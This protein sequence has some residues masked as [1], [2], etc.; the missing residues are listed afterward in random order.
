MRYLRHP[1]VVLLLVLAGAVAG[2]Q[3]IERSGLSPDV[4][5]GLARGREQAVEWIMEGRSEGEVAAEVA[6]A[7]GYLERLRLGLGSPFRLMDYALRDPRLSDSTRVAVAWS[8]LARTLDGEA[9]EIDPVVLDGVDAAGA[10]ARP[11]LGQYHLRLIEGAVEEARDPRSGELAVRLAYSLAAA[12]ASVSERAPML[13]AQVAALLRDRKLARLD[14]LRLLRAAQAARMD[15]VWLVPAWRAGRLFEVEKPPMTPLALEAE[16]EALELAP[17]L[18]EALRSLS[19]RLAGAETPPPAAPASVAPL[20]GWGAAQKLV[21]LADTLNMPPETPVVVA[22]GVYRRELLER[23]RLAEAERAA[24]QRFLER[25]TS[26]ERLAAEH[27]LLLQRRP[28]AATRASLAR[29]LLSAAVALRA[30]AQEEVWFPG[31][32]AP[33]T[34]ELQERF[35]L[36]AIEFDRSVPAAWRPYYRRMLAQAIADLQ[37][38]LPSLTLRGLRVRFGERNQGV[39]LAVHD[40]NTRT[41]YL[42]PLTGAGTIAHEIAHDLDWQV[43]WRRYRVRGDYGTDRA[44]RGRRADRLAVS[45]RGLTSASL[46]PPE[47][48]SKRPL[49]HAHRPAEVFARSLDWFVVVSLAREGRMNGYLSSVQD[50][51]LTGYGTVRP[52]DVT[53]TAGAALVG[54]LDEVAPLYAETRDWFLKSYGPGRALTPYDLIRHVLEAPIPEDPD[55]LAGGEATNPLEL[56]G[57]EVLMQRFAA[58]E[59]ARDGAFAAID[60]WIC[61]TPGAAYDGRLETLRRRLVTLAA[62]ARA[63]GIALAYATRLAGDE[64]RAWMW[65]AFYGAPWSPAAIDSVTA[66]HLSAVAERARAVAEVEIT[67]ETPGFDLTIAPRHCAASPLLPVA[68]SLNLLQGAPGPDRAA[69]PVEVRSLSS[70]A[71][72]TSAAR[73]GAQATPQRV[74][75]PH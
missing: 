37:R 51:M 41:I 57:N 14:A 48:G 26:G 61:K 68:A 21:A 25:A 63:R 44:V 15:P 22:V 52:P 54:I 74:A 31:F 50:D 16:R 17:R 65:G 19:V 7:L 6:V 23:P 12:E 32:P 4:R 34:T 29:G 30:Y 3:G 55:S 11:G 46:L 43:A 67:A 9:Y 45:L 75:L 60:A 20:L 62:G 58:I 59:R 73:P 71:L 42:P 36:A 13:A 5:R 27:V 64:G 53:G 10:G 38:V 33:S 35:G 24:R 39:A 47:P 28:D 1:R 2:C 56:P 72:P 8:L 49:S 69:R 18:A 66:E 70:S 40:P